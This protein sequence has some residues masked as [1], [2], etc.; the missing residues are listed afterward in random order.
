[1]RREWQ[2]REAFR[3]GTC[4]FVKEVGYRHF[5]FMEVIFFSYEDFLSFANG[6][7]LW[8]EFEDNVFIEMFM[9]FVIFMK[10]TANSN[11]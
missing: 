3:R 5:V 6:R 9:F 8:E 2:E 7:S 11:V 10:W 4:D 1:M